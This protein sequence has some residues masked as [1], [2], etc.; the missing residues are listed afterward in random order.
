MLV[1]S[2]FIKTKFGFLTIP[3][4]QEAFKMFVAKEFSEIKVFRILDCIVVGEVLNAFIDFRN[5]NLRVYEQKKQS[6]MLE[7]E[8]KITPDKEFKIMSEAINKKY[9]EYLE[10]KDIQEP[11]AHIFKE[12][13][14]RSII[15]M[16]TKET[17]KLSLYYDNKIKEASEQLIDEFKN[18]SET[19][20]Y[21]R[22]LIK[23]VLQSIINQEDNL[24]AKTKIEMR[25]KKLVLIDFF[26]NQNQLKKEKII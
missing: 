12:L 16:P 11:F 3:E 6:V 7:K 9:Y 4:I 14:E 26:K 1:V 5:E 21:K 25:A 17:P 20:K 23:E 15:K 2:D 10:S 8:N 19:D 13:I 22:K 18:T 24:E